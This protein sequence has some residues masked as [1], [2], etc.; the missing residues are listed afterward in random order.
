MVSKTWFHTL[1][2]DFMFLLFFLTEDF[3]FLLI[4]NFYDFYIHIFL[5]GYSILREKREINEKAKP[6]PHVPT[7]HLIRYQ[8]E[9]N[10]KVEQPPISKTSSVE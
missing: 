4:V 7:I 2:Y 9:S 10:L 6:L 8:C 5:L 3:M 1:F